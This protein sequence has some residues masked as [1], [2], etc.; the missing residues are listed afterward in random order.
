MG[1]RSRG[2]W[3]ASRGLLGGT[4]ENY[5][6][7]FRLS[8]LRIRIKIY[9]DSDVDFWPFWAR[10][11]VPLGV[12]LGLF[13]YLFRPK[14]V[15]DPYSNHL[16]FEK[17]IFT[18]HYVFSCF[19]FF[20][21]QDGGQRWL[22]IAPGSRLKLARDAKNGLQRA[23]KVSQFER[24]MASRWLPNLHVLAC[25]S[26]FRDLLTNLRFPMNCVLRSLF[27]LAANVDFGNKFGIYL[28]RFWHLRSCMPQEASR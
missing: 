14:W 4:P 5:K 11:W 1:R 2:A 9:V 12:M 28:D 3:A 21:A 7:H 25:W 15:P 26:F 27:K 8:T 17:L 13:W 16:I 24:K 22:K 10:S 18:K 20:V 19:L 6:G 23:S